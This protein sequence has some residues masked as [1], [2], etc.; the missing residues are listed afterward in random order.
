M[1]PICARLLSDDHRLW[2]GSVNHPRSVA[3]RITTVLADG[4]EQ[5]KSPADI[6]ADDVAGQP[7]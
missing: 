6:R 7:I 5:P 2:T 3:P 4:N 1:W